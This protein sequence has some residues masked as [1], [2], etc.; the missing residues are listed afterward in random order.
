MPRREKFPVRPIGSLSRPERYRFSAGVWRRRL[1]GGRS[2]GYGGD[3]GNMPQVV[4]QKK[5]AAMGM[6]VVGLLGGVASGK[7]TVARL[8]AEA[9]AGVLDADRAGHEVL[10]L[11][12][13]RQAARSRWGESVFDADGQIDRARLAGIVFAPP[14]DGPLERQFL[15]ELTHPRIGRV[16]LKQ[17]DELAAGAC[18]VA[19]LDAPLLL[20]AGWDRL[21]N[22]LVFVDVPRELRL[23]RALER[24]WSSPEFEARERAQIA[25]ETK[26]SRA[27]LIIENSGDLEE[28]R[29]QVAVVAILGG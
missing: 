27:D 3:S 5:V 11:P 15:E 6:K 16:L 21:C 25:V 17:A 12:D 13:V 28:T 1:A 26:R 8:L 20:E 19:V 4:L 23:A 22:T 2:D 29:R 18:R 7:S 10:S 14:P 9:G 24:G